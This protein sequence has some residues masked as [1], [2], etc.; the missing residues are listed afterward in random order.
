MNIIFDLGRLWVHDGL[1]NRPI[2]S[3]YLFGRDEHPRRHAM[4]GNSRDCEVANV[5]GVES[6]TLSRLVL[7]QPPTMASILSTVHKGTAFEKRSL[8]LLQKHLS[9]SLQHVGGKSDGGIDLQGWWWLPPISTLSLDANS[10]A[11][12]NKEKILPRRIR[13]LAQCKATKTKL[14]PNVVRELE[15]V[16]YRF[17][18]E[19]PNGILDT[20]PRPE[21]TALDLIPGANQCIKDDNRTPQS[22]VALL[23][24][25]APFTR[26]TII[27]AISS[28]LPFFLLHLPDSSAPVTS[29]HGQSEAHAG[30]S[31]PDAIGT[32]IWNKALHGVDGLLKG[33]LEARW[34]RNSK[35]G[36]RPGLWWQGKRMESWVPPNLVDATNK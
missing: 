36:G 1:V 12:T 28:P 32:A 24:S 30:L 7:N 13:V 5:D 18:A 14:G 8:S 17:I 11:I 35:G 25:Q 19:K 27:R 3:R 31:D 4:N 16:L 9:M 33:E 20:A 10:V 34:E 23:I 2:E 22:P 15:G 26:S 6:H 21:N 29:A